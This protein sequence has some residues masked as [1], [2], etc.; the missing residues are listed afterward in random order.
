MISKKKQA[1]IQKDFN[2]LCKKHKVNL[3]PTLKITPAGI[4]PALDIVPLKK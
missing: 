1:E 3:V 4:K 2:A